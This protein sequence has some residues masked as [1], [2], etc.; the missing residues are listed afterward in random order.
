MANGIWS[1]IPDEVCPFL[2]TDGPRIGICGHRRKMGYKNV[3]GWKGYGFESKNDEVDSHFFVF[4]TTF[5]PDSIPV[6]GPGA[7]NMKV[8]NCL[9]WKTLPFQKKNHAQLRK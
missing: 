9:F 2:W 5:A 7:S 8:F 3:S 6:S 4:V 1:A